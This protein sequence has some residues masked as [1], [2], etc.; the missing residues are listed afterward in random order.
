[1]KLFDLIDTIRKT[2]KIT[3]LRAISEV[4]PTFAELSSAEK[5]K[6]HGELHNTKKELTALLK[7]IQD[8]HNLLQTF[9]GMKG[10]NRQ[11]AILWDEIQANRG[12]V[13]VLSEQRDALKRFIFA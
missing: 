8:G 2:P 12:K 11:K 1:M 3:E 4:P 9:K 13:K 6:K 7:E 5:R 10:M